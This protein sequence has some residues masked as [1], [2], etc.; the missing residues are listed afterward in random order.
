[1][2]SIAA[3][4]GLAKPFGPGVPTAPE[5]REGGRRLDAAFFSTANATADRNRN[6]NRD[7]LYRTHVKSMPSGGLY[8]ES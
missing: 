3:P 6:N 2:F 1:M 8:E 4:T 7:I 5:L